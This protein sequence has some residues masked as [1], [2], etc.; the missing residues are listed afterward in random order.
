MILTLANSFAY[1]ILAIG[2]GLVLGC[3]VVVVFAGAV[4]GIVWST[5]TPVTEMQG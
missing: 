1:L 3:A 4:Y 2:L 5:L